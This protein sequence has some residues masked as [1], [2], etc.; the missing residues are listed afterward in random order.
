MFRLFFTPEWFNGWDVIF[1]LIGL[2]VTLLIT[3]YS[4]RIYRVNKENKF[5]YL[6][7][8]FMLLS[9]GL[10]FKTFTSSVLYFTPVRDGIAEVLRP[11]A[12]QGLAH[13]LVFYRTAFFFQ[14]ATMLS[15]WLLIFFIS[16]KSRARL[17]KF[18]EITQMALFIYL[19]LLVSL[20][21]NW[22][23]SV[24][25]TT[26]TVLLGLITLNY[27]KNY[28]NTNRN[29][30]ALKVMFS[31]LLILLGH[32]F[33]VFV[34]LSERIYVIGEIII[35]LGFLLLLYTYKKITRRERR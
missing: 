3:A 21:S 13:S 25:Y 9:L 8:A 31:F 27:Y 34:F 35:L 15:G 19:V 1:D 17:R 14:M 4:L 12:G 32:L 30:Q 20:V 16:Q 24:F 23:Y 10:L 22:K 29:S 7:L 33:L 11:L 6:S 26:S 28:L 18:H 5:A 2:L